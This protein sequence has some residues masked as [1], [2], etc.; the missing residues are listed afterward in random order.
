MVDLLSYLY[1]TYIHNYLT[2]AHFYDYEA[3]LRNNDPP[4]KPGPA[5]PTAPR[6]A[7]NQADAPISELKTIEGHSVRAWFVLLY[8]HCQR[9]NIFARQLLA[10]WRCPCCPRNTEYSTLESCSEIMEK[11]DRK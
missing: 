1:L 5:Y 10:Y 4:A 9:N 11:Y 8:P 7:Y 6:W 2:G 3:T